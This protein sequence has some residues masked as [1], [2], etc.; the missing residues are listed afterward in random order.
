MEETPP[1]EEFT[2]DT[3]EEAFEA[4]KK[5]ELLHALRYSAIESTR[6]FGRTGMDN[7][8]HVFF[9]QKYDNQKNGNE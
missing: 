5:H 2:H 8:I 4:I 7:Y 3:L 6:N 9:L 1:K